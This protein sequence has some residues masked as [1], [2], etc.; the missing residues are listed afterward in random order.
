MSK[1]TDPLFTFEIIKVE[2]ETGL[3]VGFLYNRDQAPLTWKAI[4]A[5]AIQTCDVGLM[6][7][8]L[9]ADLEAES[10]ILAIRLVLV[11]RAPYTALKLT[12]TPKRWRT[13]VA[14]VGVARSTKVFR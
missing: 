3:D 6:Y 4:S 9:T 8:G 7:R 12:P 2:S 14:V 1:I 5:A 11:S 10:K 13:Q